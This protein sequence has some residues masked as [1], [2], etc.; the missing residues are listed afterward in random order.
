MHETLYRSFDGQDY[1]HKELWVLDDSPRP[2]Q[3]LVDMAGT[4]TRLHYIHDP[5]RLRTGA[6]RNRLIAL[7]TG[8]V[9]AH[10][11][12]DDWYASNYLS[13]MLEVL[14]SQDAD[15]VKLSAWNE[16]SV[17]HNR[18]SLYD[19]REEGGAPGNLWGW[20]FTYMYRRYVASMVSFP[21]AVF[22]EDFAF[23]ERLRMHGLRTALIDHGAHWVEHR[24]HGANVSGRRV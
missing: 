18:V 15:F 4:D 1:E 7:S 21:N 8:S 10:F 11:D 6:K 19:A 12:D 24:L 2:S 9:I 13:S 23:Y 14:V 17:A 16:A 3:L 22:G 5:A 20:G